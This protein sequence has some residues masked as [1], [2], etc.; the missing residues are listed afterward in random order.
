MDEYVYDKMNSVTVQNNDKEYTF[1]Y[2]SGLEEY[3]H[4][5]VI[6][7]GIQ[8]NG[9]VRGFVG[10]LFYRTKG[11]SLHDDK[12]EVETVTC[13]KKV[14]LARITVS[15]QPGYAVVWKYNFLKD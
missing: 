14:L 15:A 12:K 2:I 5:I 1:N 7:S 6:E 9:L 13:F 8:I 11:Y 10:D 4:E 3:D